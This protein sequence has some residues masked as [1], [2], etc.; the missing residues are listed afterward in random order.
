MTTY[1]YARVSTDGQTLDAQVAALKAAGAERIFSEKQS[2]AKTDRAA[3]S[4][5]LAVLGAGDVLLVNTRLDRLARS[6]RDLLNVLAT[7]SE[8][9][10]GF[11]SLAQLDASG[12]ERLRVSRPWGDEHDYHTT[13]NSPR[14]CYGPVYF[15]RESEPYMTLSLAGT[16]LDAGVSVAE[17]NLKLIWDVVSQIKVGQHRQAYVTGGSSHILVLRDTDMTKLAQVQ[18]ARTAGTKPVQEGQDIHG[19]KVLSAYAPCFEVAA[20]KL[21]FGQFRRHERVHFPFGS[22]YG[23]EFLYCL[24]S[25]GT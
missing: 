16:R 25:A 9:E 6:T 11:R 18:A 8:R 15:R 1:G 24:G 19:H 14:P 13:Q 17:V 20:S 21:V 22:R 7:I 10:A 12:R 4:R 2:R 23:S 3:L 5:A